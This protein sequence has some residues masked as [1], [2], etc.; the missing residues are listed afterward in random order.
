[1]LNLVLTFLLVIDDLQHL[2]QYVIH[3]TVESVFLLT[4]WMFVKADMH[5]IVYLKF[6][7]TITT[8]GNCMLCDIVLFVSSL[9]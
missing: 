7:S 5:S 1:M 3:F 6:V 9:N 4:V 8:K 2:E